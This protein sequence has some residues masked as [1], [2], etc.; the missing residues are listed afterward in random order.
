VVVVLVVVVVV[1]VVVF[2][3]VSVLAPVQ[4]EA[5]VSMKTINIKKRA[6][7]LR[8]FTIIGL[9]SFHPLFILTEVKNPEA[10]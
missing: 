8:V 10:G 6:E 5:N 7:I 4:P 2:E 9:P 3:V 1:A